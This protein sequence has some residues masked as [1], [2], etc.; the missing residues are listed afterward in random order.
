MRILSLLILAL[1]FSAATVNDA[2][3]ANEAYNNGDYEQAAELYRQ[4]IEQNPD[5][6][7]L[8]FNLGN[9]L[10]QMGRADEARESY[11]RYKR[12]AENNQER[13]MADYNVGRMLI[14]N[15]QY[16]EASGYF[17]EAL[18][19]NPSDADARHNYELALRRQ[20]EQEQ[21]QQQQPDSGDDQE[22][23]PEGEQQQDQSD[24]QQD[25]E[26]GD[27]EQESGQQP[28]QPQDQEGSEGEQE[29]TT[30]RNI[31][32][33]EAENILEALAQLERELLENQKKKASE[34]SVNNEQD[35]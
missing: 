25:G 8:H 4:A 35:W 14:D 15:E 21:D 12:L 20:Q 30:P 34:T 26:S 27:Q 24:Q 1:F 2:R 22:Q 17:K 10:Y 31:S 7:R 13:S 9:S 19:N 18:K 11:E 29:Q 28:Q 16:E 3:K 6:P 23:D 5:D 32:P 33:E